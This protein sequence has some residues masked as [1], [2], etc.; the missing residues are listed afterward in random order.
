MT[1][2]N[3]GG[4]VPDSKDDQENPT[5]HHLLHVHHSRA[6]SS[7]RRNQ[8]R[9]I[10]GYHS[11]RTALLH[12][13]HQLLHQESCY[14]KTFE[15][16]TEKLMRMQQLDEGNQL[17]NLNLDGHGTC[18]TCSGSVGSSGTCHAEEKT[19]KLSRTVFPAL[20]SRTT[21][22]PQA[23]RA[24][25]T[26]SSGNPLQNDEPRP[27]PSWPTRSS[28]VYCKCPRL[29][30]PIPSTILKLWCPNQALHSSFQDWPVQK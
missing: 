16:P 30:D 10:S 26:F 17:L 19:Q 15:F 20:W 13:S 2:G 23:Y 7:S 29:H 12:P 27:E 24:F 8:G 1:C 18:G 4:Q 22:A 11:P 28:R 25:S 5:K 9:D 6:I 14:H 3:R 21:D